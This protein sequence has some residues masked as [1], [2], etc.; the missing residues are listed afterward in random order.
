MNL[1]WQKR[2]DASAY[3]DVRPWVQPN[4]GFL[5]QLRSLEKQ[6]DAVIAAVEEVEIIDFESH[7]PRVQ[8]RGVEHYPELRFSRKGMRDLRARSKTAAL[9]PQPVDDQVGKCNSRTTSGYPC[10][11]LS[12][13]FL[14]P[15]LP[16][17]KQ[18]CIATIV[19]SQT[20]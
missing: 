8:L 9:A 19:D 11:R 12:C 17:T 1:Y 3:S 15:H 14:G 4:P 6:K 2:A 18:F 13:S 7:N 5:K 16:H 20:L 10:E